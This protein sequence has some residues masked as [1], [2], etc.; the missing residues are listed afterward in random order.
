M[1]IRLAPMIFKSFLKAFIGWTGLLYFFF[2]NNEVW[3][4]AIG[5]TLFFASGQLQT[6]VKPP[7]EGLQI[8]LVS[9]DDFL[10]AW[11]VTIGLA[12][13]IYYFYFVI[14][15]NHST[16]IYTSTICLSLLWESQIVDDT[17][18]ILSSWLSGDMFNAAR[19]F[20]Q[21]LM[22]LKEK[23]VEAFSRNLVQD[24]LCVL[25]KLYKHLIMNCTKMNCFLLSQMSQLPAA[26]TKSVVLSEKSN[27]ERNPMSIDS[28]NPKSIEKRKSPRDAR[29]KT[30]RDVA[31]YFGALKKE[32]YGSTK[33]CP[34]I[35]MVKST[36]YWRINSG[37]KVIYQ[38]TVQL[39]LPSVRNEET[40]RLGT[41]RKRGGHSPVF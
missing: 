31:S 37:C 1:D 13:F 9:S 17:I 11:R 8:G 39:S 40:A 30:K 22:A 3:G 10:E 35:S 36:Y 19:K 14:Y 15:L 32:I 18:E 38:P 12:S 6:A 2:T 34:I 27:G 29:A 4:E 5:L 41:F 21:K 25:C 16:T 24:F 26:T 28:R 33:L 7:L 23:S 20:F